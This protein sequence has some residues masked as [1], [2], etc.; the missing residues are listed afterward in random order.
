MTGTLVWMDLMDH[1]EERVPPVTE[2]NQDCL[3]CLANRVSVALKE[4]KERQ[5]IMAHLA[6][7]ERMVS[8]G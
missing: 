5:V 4:T 3:A 2:D 1:R 8:M 7:Q 6:N